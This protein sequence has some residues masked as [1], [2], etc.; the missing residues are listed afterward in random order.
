MSTVRRIAAAIAKRVP[1]HVEMED[2]VGAGSLGLAEAFS[3][4]GAM[5]GHEFENFAACRIRGAMLDELRQRDSMSRCS[6]Q[7]AKR[8]AKASR[9]VEQRVGRAATEEEIAAELGLDLSGYQALS[10]KVTANRAPVAFSTLGENDDLV[11]NVADPSDHSPETRA[12]RIRLSMLISSHLEALSERKRTVLVGIYVE[13]MTLKEVG[14]SLGLTESRICQIH[15]EALAALRAALSEQDV[16]E[17][18]S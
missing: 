13:G 14:I 9:A 1:R 3:R 11:R 7:T 4:R 8:L 16:W 2:L 15:S 6:R 10:T 17:E 18:A 12:D 5:P